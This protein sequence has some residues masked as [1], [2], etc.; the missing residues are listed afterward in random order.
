MQPDAL[1]ENVVVKSSPKESTGSLLRRSPRRL[2]KKISDARRL[3]TTIIT[4]GLGISRRA[5]AWDEQHQA[6]P[7]VTLITQ[8]SVIRM[9]R[10]EPERDFQAG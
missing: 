10:I 8:S 9:Y 3:S 6:D 1:L 2:L 4:A 7:K 5:D